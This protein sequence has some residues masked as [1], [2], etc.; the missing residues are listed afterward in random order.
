M[1]KIQCK[2]PELQLLD[3][4][5]KLNDLCVPFYVLMVEDGYGRV[6]WWPCRW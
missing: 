4:T 5:Y 3:A 6:R 2:F 1:Q